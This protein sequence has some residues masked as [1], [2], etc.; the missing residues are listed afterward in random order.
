MLPSEPAVFLVDDDPS[1]LKA[2]RQHL[3][4]SGF[5]VLAW[6]SPQTFLAEHD[7][8][9]AGCLVIDF[10]MP[11]ISGLEVQNELSA[12]GCERIVVFISDSSDIQ[13][14]VRAMK[15]GAASFLKKPVDTEIL[16][17]EIEQALAKDM[18]MRELTHRRSV[19]AQRLR[20]LTRR[21]YDVLRLVVAGRLNKQ[22]AVTLGIAE[23]TIKVHRGRMM[24][25]MGG[26]SLADLFAFISEAD[27]S[28]L[29]SMRRTCA[30]DIPPASL[31]EPAGADIRPRSDGA[32]TSRISVRAFR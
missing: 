6:S 18:A 13:T 16:V 29:T 32:C 30:G 17:C 27:P 4:A 8:A 21:E 1:T 26:R 19:L 11:G 20:S 14:A 24:D 22:M 15:T 3:Q 31:G 23:K 5:N 10:A 25:K 9:A 2:L 7:R 12:S 28:L